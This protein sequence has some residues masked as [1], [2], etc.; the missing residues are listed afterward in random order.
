MTR[1]VVLN[2]YFEWMYNLVC[3][4]ARFKRSSYRKLLMRLHNTEF[5]YSIENDGNRA[6]DGENL[7][8]RFAYEQGIHG[9]SRYLTGPCSVLE[10]MIA[11][12]IRCEEQIMDNPEIGDRTSK[13][14]WN[15]VSN[16]DLNKMSDSR[17]SRKFVDERLD[18][19]LDREYDYDGKYGL[20]TVEN[21]PYDLRNVEIWYQM[22]WY[23]DGIV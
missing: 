7:R 1:D 20:F 10:M 9:V 3:V 15:M 6:A 22:H 5:R 23:L 16:L 13:W 21:C 11:L 14:F 8:Y 2:E 19:F 17:F 18:I 12:S 4:G